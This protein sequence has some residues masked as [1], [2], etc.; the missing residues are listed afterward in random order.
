MGM[1]GTGTAPMNVGCTTTFHS[2]AAKGGYSTRTHVVVLGEF[3]DGTK[4]IILD[5]YI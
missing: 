1:I 3:S 5:T 2:G 4:Q